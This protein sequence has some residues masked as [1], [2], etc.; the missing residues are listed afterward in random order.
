[1]TEERAK[2]KLRAILS[3]DVVGYSRLM[4][5]DE[6]ETV[7]TLEAYREMIAEVIRNYSGRVVDSPGDNILAEFGS[8]VDA[9]EAA[10][11]IQ[12][13]LNLKNAELPENR[14]MEFRM[15]I[16][17]GDVIEEGERIYGDG[18]NI[19]A[20]IEGLAEGGG[21]CISGTAFDQIRK[22]LSLGYEYLG[23]QAVK[24]IAEPVRT[25]RVLMEPE[26]AGKVIGEKRPISRQWRWVAVALLVVAG[27]L[28]VWNFYLRPPF[29]PASVERMA[30]P[31][32]DKPS[33]AVLPFTNLSGDPE[34]EYLAD[35]FTENIISAL[36]QLPKLYVIARQSTFAYKGKPIKIRQVAEELGVRYVL[37]GSFQKSGD[38]CRITAQLIDAIGGHHLWSERYDRELKDIF[39]VQDEIAMKIITALAV[40]LTDGERARLAGKMAKNLPAYLKYWQAT[41]PYYS[42]T[43]EGNVQAQR[44]CEEA[45]ALDPKFPAA[46]LLLG[47]THNQDVVYGASKSP[48][49]SVKRAFELVKKAIALDDSFAGAHATLGVMYI[50]KERNY[51]QAI[52]QCERALDLAPNLDVANIWM[53]TVLTWAGRHEEAVRYCEQAV[54]LNP[55]PNAW[56]FRT[57]GLAYSWVARYEEAIAA[58]KKALQSSPNDLVTHL[59]L[60]TAYSW[61]GRMEEARAQAAEV[62]R[63]NPKWCISRGKGLYKNPADREL[64][65]DAKRKAGLPDCPPRRRS[66]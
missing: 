22:R 34:Q 45:I 15:G 9:V 53:G 39:A 25:Y 16:N 1:M 11:E 64:S 44:L 65:N 41:G 58:H 50:F 48:R 2:R 23:E 51:D 32:P 27:A 7:R 37:E 35:G 31:L 28:A 62:L 66:K 56:H 6:L 4:G 3:A 47:T 13:E 40:K 59:H 57:L 17:L 29:E 46:Y 36:S 5:E 38:K 63:I 55:I 20:R 60:T 14:R 24:N 33:I 26:T 18:V 54:R 8:V 19:A 61:A 52:A 12:K 10:V 30:F 49:E 43:K 42:L 21:V